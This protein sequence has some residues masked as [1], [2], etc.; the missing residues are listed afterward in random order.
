MQVLKMFLWGQCNISDVDRR[1]FYTESGCD[2][3]TTIKRP[4]N[5]PPAGL[6]AHIWPALNGVKR[7]TSCVWLTQSTRARNRC[8]ILHTPPRPTNAVTLCGFSK[9]HRYSVTYTILHH[10]HGDISEST[11]WETASLRRQ[12]SIFHV[13]LCDLCHLSLLVMPSSLSLALCSCCRPPQLQWP[14]TS[15]SS[16]HSVLLTGFTC[17]CGTSTGFEQFLQ[18]WMLLLK[19]LSGL[20]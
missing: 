11:S 12:L 17:R 20:F 8:N 9:S 5:C 3:Q 13:G 10:E 14:S 7:W 19:K 18:R 2:A 15:W 1:L 4:P 6:K 16:C